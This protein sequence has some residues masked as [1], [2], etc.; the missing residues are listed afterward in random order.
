MNTITLYE[1]DFLKWTEQ[2]VDYLQK[3]DWDKLDIENLVEEVEASGRSKQKELGGYLQVLL[4]YLL[5]CEY[6]PER[7]TGSWNTTLSNCRDKI[8]DCL[9]DTPS[10]QRFLRDTE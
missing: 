8:Q 2:Q 5:K 7:R 10:L 6:Q 4:M 1:Q 9:E 3:G